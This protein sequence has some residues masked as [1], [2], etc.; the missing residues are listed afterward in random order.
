MCLSPP[1]PRSVTPLR[2]CVA[3]LDYLAKLSI[4]S[5]M[6]PVFWL[7]FTPIFYWR[8]FLPCSS[9]VKVAVLVGP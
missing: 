1:A 2:R 3:L 7:I 8:V 9:T 5:M 6:M 4:C